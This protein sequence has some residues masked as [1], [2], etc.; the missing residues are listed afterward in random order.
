MEDA[1]Q[2]FEI[3]PPIQFAFNLKHPES[4]PG[5]T[6]VR[7]YVFLHGSYDL[8]GM[9]RGVYVAEVPFVGGNLT[10]RLHVPLTRQ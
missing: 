5:V 1:L 9:Y 7:A 8:P 10:V 4:G 2:E 6:D 3:L